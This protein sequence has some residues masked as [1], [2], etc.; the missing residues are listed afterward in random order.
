MAG[1]LS[2]LA[3]V[4]Q[5]VGGNS[6]LVSICLLLLLSKLKFIYLFLVSFGGEEEGAEWNGRLVKGDCG[7]F[8]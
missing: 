2:V 1:A 7:C 3:G 8:C 6:S 5:R 4:G